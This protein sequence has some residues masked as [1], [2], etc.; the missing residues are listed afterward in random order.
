MVRS[1]HEFM[2]YDVSVARCYFVESIAEFFITF[3]TLGK[4]FVYI[5]G[6][7]YPECFEIL[8]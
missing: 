4:V 2:I 5:L 6:G 8:E 7:N 1:R 3:S